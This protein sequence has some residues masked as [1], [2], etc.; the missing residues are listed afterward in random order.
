MDRMVEHA[1]H[2]A[3]GTFAVTLGQ[4]E[5]GLPVRA[6]FALEKTYAGYDLPDA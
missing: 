1:R 4:E 6:R 2:H 3:R 5:G